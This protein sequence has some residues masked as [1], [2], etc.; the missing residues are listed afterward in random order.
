MTIEIG[1]NLADT[2]LGIA[3]FVPVVVFLWVVK[4]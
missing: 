3:M 4:K 1:K 2:I